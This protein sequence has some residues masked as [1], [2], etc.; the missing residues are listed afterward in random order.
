MKVGLI[1]DPHANVRGLRAAIE[2]VRVSGAE[3]II[4]AG[5]AVGYYTEVNETIDELRRAVAHVTLGNHDAMLL[6]KL[7]TDDEH[8]KLY[9][10]DYTASV[11]TAD[12]RAWLDSL[13]ES[14]E[15]EL[16]GLAIA[17]FHGSPWA[18]LTEYVYPD[19]RDFG[20]FA[21]LGVDVVVLGHTHRQLVHE[22]GGVT[23][24]NPGSCGLPRDNPTGAPYALLD[25]ATREVTLGRVTSADLE[26]APS[27]FL[28][29]ISSPS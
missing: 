14:L 16:G 8:R 10:L 21:Q 27:P 6:G 28:T 26:R 11:I 3:V 18:P 2:A 22:V 7:P 25:T 17:V 4:S 29:S 24:V 5:D 12:N 19:H 23:I 9:G 1:S 15:I 13:P 20:R